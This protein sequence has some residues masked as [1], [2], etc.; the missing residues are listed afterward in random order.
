MNLRQ[1]Q[2]IYAVPSDVSGVE[3]GDVQLLHDGETESDALSPGVSVSA[4]LK[5]V[6]TLI[7]HRICP[8][9]VINLTLALAGI[10]TSFQCETTKR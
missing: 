2:Q 5:L 4:I 3:V 10:H 6:C 8:P 9:D 7:D 1:Q